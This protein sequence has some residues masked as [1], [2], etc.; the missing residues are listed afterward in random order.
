[1]APRQVLRRRRELLGFHPFA[2]I[3]RKKRHALQ[4]GGDLVASFHLFIVRCGLLLFSQQI[5]LGEFKIA[6]ERLQIR[7]RGE[8][9]HAVFFRAAHDLF[10]TL[11]RVGEVLFKFLV[12]FLRRR[13]RLFARHR[14]FEMVAEQIDHPRV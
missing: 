9:R 3:F 4:F 11:D 7:P 13:G 5:I 10:G 1:M 2:D 8:I 6:L 14:G 12:H